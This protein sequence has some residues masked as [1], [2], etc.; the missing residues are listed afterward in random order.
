MHRSMRLAILPLGVMLALMLADCAE[1]QANF[2]PH[3]AM[4]SATTPGGSITHVQASRD[5]W[6]KYE[7]GRAT[8]S[9]DRRADLVDQCVKAKMSGAVVR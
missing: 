5:C 8:L 6:M 7:N 3:A 9:L 2:G 4:A 1:D